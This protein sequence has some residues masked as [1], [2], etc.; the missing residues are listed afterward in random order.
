MARKVAQSDPALSIEFFLS[1]FYTHRSQLFAPFKG[2]GVNVVSFH[3][4]VIDGANMEDTDLY[5][6]TRRPGFSIFCSQALGTTELVNQFYS[7]RNLYGEVIPFFDSSL[8]LATFNTTSWTNIITK[9]TTAQGYITPIQNMVYFSDGA[10]TDMQ[11]WQSALAMSTTNPSAWGIPAPTLTPTIFA[12]GCWLPFTGKVLNN[13]VLDPNG[14][15]EVVTKTFGGSGVT[16]ANQPIWPTTTAAVI[17]DGSIQWTN[18]GPLSIW[19]P[20]IAF[21]VP[22]VVVDT[23]GNLELATTVTNPVQTWNATTTYQVGT[24]VTFG[25]NYWTA[26]AINT[27]QPPNPGTNWVLSQNPATTGA[28]APSASNTPPNPWSTVVGGVTVDGAY[29]WTN[30]GPGGLTESFGTSYVYCYRTIYGHLSTAS[31]VSLNTGSIFGPT[32]ASARGC[33]Q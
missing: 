11:K 30:I 22:V 21:P 32:A 31:P 7:F 19:Q 23:N 6:W 18:M 1:G 13:A 8:Q 2:I 12:L 29:T 24:S 27:D 20:L 26:I 3:D 10:S 16:G 33:W 9:T 15:V 28:T 17:A 25:G 4:P 5:E 14:N